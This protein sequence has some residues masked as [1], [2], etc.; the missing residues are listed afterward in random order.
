MEAHEIPDTSVKEAE[1]E[2][3]QV[4]ETE[5]GKN[6]KHEVK[7]NRKRPCQQT[8][9][10]HTDGGNNVSEDQETLD[11]AGGDV[12]DNADIHLLWN[13]IIEMGMNLNA[14]S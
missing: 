12:L 11:I 5:K 2:D 10:Y 1:K 3:T 8:Q 7:K 13:D 4:E 6:E 14:P 9:Y